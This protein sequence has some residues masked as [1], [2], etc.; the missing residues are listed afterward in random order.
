[1]KASQ[2][3][4][5]RSDLGRK[6]GLR[7]TRTRDQVPSANSFRSASCLTSHRF[8]SH[9]LTS[10]LLPISARTQAPECSARRSVQESLLRFAATQLSSSDTNAGIV[11]GVFPGPLIGRLDATPSPKISRPDTAFISVNRKPLQGIAR[12]FAP[13][14]NSFRPQRAQCALRR[15]GSSI[16]L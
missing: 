15:T 6:T 16:D 14:N 11:D 8:T 3:M 10:P 4:R 9:R 2:R 7:P 5:D 12:L 13:M 1:M